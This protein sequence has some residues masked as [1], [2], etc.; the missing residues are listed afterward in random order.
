MGQMTVEEAQLHS[1]RNI[2]TRS[3]GPF[4]EVEVDV[5]V[6][7]VEEGDAFVLCSDGLS[8]MISDDDITKHCRALSVHRRASIAWSIMPTLRA[9]WIILQRL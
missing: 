3:L 6:E 9:V 2:I 8:G 4:P 5:F 1:M 7:P